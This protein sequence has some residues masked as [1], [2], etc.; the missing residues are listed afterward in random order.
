MVSIDSSIEKKHDMN[1]GKQ[2]SFGLAVQAIQLLKEQKVNV[3]IAS[4]ITKQNYL[5]L[6]AIEKLAQ[7]NQIQYISFLACR[8][9]NRIA[10]PLEKEYIDFVLNSI[11]ENKQYAFH[12]L[13]LIPYIKS[14][15]KN[16]RI[17]ERQCAAAIS[18]NSC[19]AN[20]TLT[21]APNGDI[22]TCDL[23]DH[24]PI[25]NV[26]NIDLNDFALSDLLRKT[27]MKGCSIV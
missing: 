27:N 5:E 6:A 14:W 21:L 15:Y 9:Q 20:Q 7:E 25:G 8:E 2:G 16:N 10:C 23:I 19:C 17:T 13:R 3:G 4:T 26:Y 24:T 12:D 22:F 1:R 18:A 11:I